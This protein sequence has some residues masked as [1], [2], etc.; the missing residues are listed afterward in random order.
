MNADGAAGVLAIWNDVRAGREPEFDF[1]FKS[2]HFAERLAV[3][4]W[5]SVV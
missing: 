3:P 2:E 5:K 4:G 1:W